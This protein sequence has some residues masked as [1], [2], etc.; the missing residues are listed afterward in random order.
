MNEET[1]NAKATPA[2]G[3][4]D[5]VLTFIDKPWKA[6]VIA[7]F[8]TMGGLGWLVYENRV[9]IADAL[10]HEPFTR[11]VLNIEAFVAGADKLLRDTRADITVLAELNLN[12]N[13]IVDRIGIDRN[14]V[15]WIPIEGPQPALYPGSDMSIVIKFLRNEVV[16]G[17]TRDRPS[18]D[19]SALYAAGYMRVCLVV[20][21]PVL[22]S[23]VGVLMLGWKDALMPAVEDRSETVMLTYA[24]KFATW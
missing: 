4:L 22:G 14:G 13:I 3:M 24:L 15:R 6:V 2:L 1:P 11:P 8:A 7:V 19:M 5:R 18:A 16:C 9:R 20:V 10:L 23:S 17:D 12:A 21:P